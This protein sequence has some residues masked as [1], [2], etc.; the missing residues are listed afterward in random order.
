[1][2][3]VWPT[4]IMYTGFFALPSS[5]ALPAAVAPVTS[6]AAPPPRPWCCAAACAAAPYPS[7]SPPRSPPYPAAACLSAPLHA[8]HSLRSASS[9]AVLHARAEIAGKDWLSWR[10]ARARLP[11]GCV[12]GM[13]CPGGQPPP[14]P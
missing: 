1:M 3:G 13:R 11:A 2:L 12:S 14:A 7:P 9:G 8:Q 10:Q 4:C 5:P 6:P